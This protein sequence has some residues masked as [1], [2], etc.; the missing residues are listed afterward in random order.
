VFWP[1]AR[2][3]H[4]WMNAYREAG[5]G[6]AGKGPKGWDV[7][8][9]DVLSGVDELIRGGIVDPDRMGLYGF[10]NGGGVVNDLV[11]RTN[12]FKCAVSV[13]GV[14]PD[15]L[16]PA[17]PHTDTTIPTFEGG[18]SPFDDPAAYV[19]L[20]AIF[21]LKAVTTPMLLA[22]G[23]NDGDFLLGTIELY[24]GLRWL[25]KD[26][27]FLRYPGQ[28]HGFSGA[29]LKDFWERETAFFDDHLKR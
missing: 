28:G 24:N 7:T 9:D 3:P 26:V 15:W 25:G 10:S 4:T 20:S 22:V 17:F 19:Q 8:L 14:Y 2:A 21:H 18:V 13:A 6:E 23:D 1:N 11:T 27:T 5:F 29:A 16:L 12:R